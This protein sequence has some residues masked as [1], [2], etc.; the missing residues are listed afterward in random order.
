MSKR[1]VTSQQRS[2]SPRGG[3]LGPGLP[4]VYAYTF[5]ALYLLLLVFP[6]YWL[7]ITS[8]KGADEFLTGEG[9]DFLPREPEFDA[10]EAVWFL[11]PAFYDSLIVSVSA[12]VIATVVGAMAGY[13]IAHIRR[14][15]GAVLIA[16]LAVRILPP[17]SIILPI[18]LLADDL[19]LRDTHF[20][21]ILIYAVFALPFTVLITFALFRQI[22]QELEEAALVDGSTR[23]QVARYISIP[24]MKPGLVAAF[25]FA[26]VF[27]WTDFI[28]AILL[29]GDD[30][31]TIP[32]TI[33]NL[34]RGAMGPGAL[35][36]LIS[37]LS[38]AA[39]LV[40]AAIVSALIYAILRRRVTIDSLGA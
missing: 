1:N 40:P 15:A 13:S 2:R 6:L 32:I 30:V 8:F 7:I 16:F 5:L 25:V 24:L 22:P 29:T 38:I 11:R 23:I 33:G 27:A 37:A 10:Y 26:L 18:F 31:A 9:Q 3:R 39:G 4:A 12:A 35:S 14:G 17:I 19:G 21:L 20:E 28:F 34:T 36:P